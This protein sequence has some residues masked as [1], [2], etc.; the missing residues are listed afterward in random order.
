MSDV[1]DHQPGALS[2]AAIWALERLSQ[3]RYGRDTPALSWSV[4][5]EL[6]RAGFVTTS[7]NSR[8]VTSVTQAGRNYLLQR[9]QS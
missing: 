7:A 5:Q 9:A 8:G 3:P 1:T 2:H 6:R 4:T